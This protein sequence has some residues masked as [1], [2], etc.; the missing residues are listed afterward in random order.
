MSETNPVQDNQPT[1]RSLLRST[2][3][4]AA[5]AVVILVAIVMPAEYGVDP[6][7]VGRVL[8][9]TKMGKIKR[10]LA[11]EAAAE[12]TV[13]TTPADSVRPNVASSA[14]AASSADTSSDRVTSIALG[15]GQ[16]REI[17]LVMR[18]GARAQ[19]SWSTDRGVVSHTTHGDTV[20]AP[21]GKFHEY[22]KGT[23][24]RA[25]SG[26]IVAVFTGNHG[27]YWRNRTKEVVTVTLRTRGEYDD[28]K[29]IK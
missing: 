21:P 17:K 27:W 8:G 6:T 28:L 13:A 12:T 9:L 18:K 19:Y 22:A 24:V 16:A 7:G 29:E 11:A 14:A 5:V 2:L 3:I 4:A 15:P 23:G 25:D 20:N 10:A 1:S 26:V